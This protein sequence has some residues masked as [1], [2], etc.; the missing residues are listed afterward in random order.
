MRV[1][2][3]HSPIARGALLTAPY[4]RTPCPPFW[5]ITATVVLIQKTSLQKYTASSV[6]YCR[7]TVKEK[8]RFTVE[9][10]GGVELHIVETSISATCNG[11]TTAF[12][13][14]LESECEVLLE[15]IVVPLVGSPFAKSGGTLH[16]WP[17]PG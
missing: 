15:S 2:P 3:T 16:L 5:L 14:V 11:Y 7:I 6:R 12:C 1:L 13:T 17:S 9:R 10:H 8:G 4:G